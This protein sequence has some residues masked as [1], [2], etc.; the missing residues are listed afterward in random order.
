[1]VAKEMKRPAL[2]PVP[3][4]PGDGLG[5]DVQF[6]RAARGFTAVIAV[7]DRTRT[8]SDPGATCGALAGALAVS[9]ALA[10]DAGALPLPTPEAVAP[11]PP[12]K[13][14]SAL[15]G[16]FSSPPLPPPE[17]EAP[18][19]R[20]I[21]VSL[22]A[23]PVVTVGLLEGFAAGVSTELELRVGRFTLAAGVLVLPGDSFSTSGGMAKLDLTT[24]MIRACGI[25][26]G[27]DPMRLVLCAEPWAGAL[28]ASGA[29]FDR[30]GTVPW[31]AAASSAL[32]QQRIGGPVWWGARAGLVIPL[33]KGVFTADNMGTAYPTAPVGGAWNAELRVSI[34]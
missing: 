13:V 20:K 19:P 8:M 3:G 7:G 11:A 21:R 18:A 9:I 31:G 29:G 15:P 10:L 33:A 6:Y 14:A 28:R 25:V 1:M 17:E 5:L 24:A 23:S 22:A 2:Q 32:F 26:A 4:L 30:T 34:W 16:A 12:A 27:D